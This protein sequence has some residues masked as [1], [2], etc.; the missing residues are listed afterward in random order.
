MNLTKENLSIV[1]YIRSA[2]NKFEEVCESRVE[3]KHNNAIYTILNYGL[4]VR[5]L[6]EY[7]EGYI[8][9]KESGNTKYKG[10]LYGS[11]IAFYNSMFTNNTKYR[12]KMYLTDMDLITKEFLEQSKRLK[13]IME[14]HIKDVDIDPEFRA[15]MSLTDN[16]YRKIAKVNRDD[17]EIYMWLCMKGT[18]RADKYD[19]PVRLRIAFNDATTP[20][21]HLFKPG[22]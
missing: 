5:E 2:R 6:C 15:L 10:K 9:Y 18:Y 4:I 19:I 3:A 14:D 7:L 12:R 13:G 8:K 22:K 17:M 21:M 11:T 1:T 16:Q 20:V